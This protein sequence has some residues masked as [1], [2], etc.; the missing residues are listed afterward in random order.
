MLCELLGSLCPA[1]ASLCLPNGQCA[2]IAA[3]AAALHVTMT[4]MAAIITSGMNNHACAC[5]HLHAWLAG[6]HAARVSERSFM[7]TSPACC[8]LACS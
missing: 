6:L 5:S 8:G 7:L 1:S 4:A 3:S 2:C